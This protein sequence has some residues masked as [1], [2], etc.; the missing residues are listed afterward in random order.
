[1]RT[2]E[3]T[4][5]KEKRVYKKI[6]KLLGE[7]GVQP[8]CDLKYWVLQ[9]IEDRLLDYNI[10]VVHNSNCIKIWTGNYYGDDARH[11][12]MND[13]SVASNAF[14]YGIVEHKESMYV[15]LDDPKEAK[16][17]MGNIIYTVAVIRIGD[18]IQ[19]GKSGKMYAKKYKMVWYQRPDYQPV[20]AD[21]EEIYD[22]YDNYCND[23]A[24]DWD[25]PALVEPCGV[26]EIS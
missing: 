18:I 13:K 2:I 3:M 6:Q 1:M 15:L 12:A 14:R 22:K 10:D 25:N 4:K 21:N 7:F 9:L 5:E 23:N 19:Q 11:V 26:S 24:F 17:N 20:D 16:D 8:P